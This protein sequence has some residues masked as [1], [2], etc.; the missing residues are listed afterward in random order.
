[1][2]SPSCR[3]NHGWIFLSAAGT[4][5]REPNSLPQRFGTGD[6]LFCATYHKFCSVP[7]GPLHK[8]TKPSSALQPITK[9]T[10]LQQQW[11]HA[12]NAQ[13]GTI[14]I[15]SQSN[16]RVW[17]RCDQ[18]PDGHLHSWSAVVQNRRNGSGCLTAAGQKSASTTHWQLR[19]PWLQLSGT[20][21]QMMAPPTK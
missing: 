9:G 8:Q 19:L 10:G 3:E 14:V 16:K 2:A 4:L 20:T 1:M 11:D 18:W 15:K 5:F 13:L 6:T 7:P 12:A 21:K 17:W